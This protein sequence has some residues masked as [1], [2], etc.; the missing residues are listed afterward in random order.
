MSVG[1][2]SRIL[3]LAAA[4]LAG[5]FIARPASAVD[6]GCTYPELGLQLAGPDA[7]DCGIVGNHNKEARRR[8]VECARKAINAGKPMRVGTGFHGDDVLGCDVLVVDA[9]RQYWLIALFMDFSLDM[10]VPEVFVGR[11]P[12]IDL[13]W[14]DPT[15]EGR[16]GP[17]DCPF[18]AEAFEVLRA[19]F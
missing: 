1:R 19:S 18:D 9:K 5:M 2:P 17:R 3:L 13:D 15:G 12:T 8:A 14:Q 10:K 6:L 4:V 11:C 16:F 7:V